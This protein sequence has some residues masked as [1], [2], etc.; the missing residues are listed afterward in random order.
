LFNCQK[1]IFIEDLKLNI[2]VSFKIINII[3]II[4]T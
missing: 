2:R 4:E 3:L 1:I